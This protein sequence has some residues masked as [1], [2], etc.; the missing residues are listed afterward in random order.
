VIKK[1]VGVVRTVGAGGAQHTFSEEEK[2]AF[3][4]HINQCL[5]GDELMARH[6]PLNVESDDL[7]TK[8]T[9]GIMYW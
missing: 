9:D 3:A 1:A 2:V 6:L 8:G 5:A 4:T 7:F